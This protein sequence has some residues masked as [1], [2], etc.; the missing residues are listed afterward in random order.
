M[1]FLCLNA[2]LFVCFSP[3]E[4]IYS[5]LH[6]HFV[7]VLMSPENCFNKPLILLS[8]EDSKIQNIKIFIKNMI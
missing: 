2:F 1:L 3:C 7:S 6:S 5:I 4:D 8:T